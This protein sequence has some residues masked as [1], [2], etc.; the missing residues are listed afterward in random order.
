M[1]G[2]ITVILFILLAETKSENQTCKVI[3]QTGF[4]EFSKEGDLL[5]GGVF[6]M[7]STRTVIDNGY[8]AI[9]YTVCKK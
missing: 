2:W 1:M 5:I 3:G 6:S 7:S 4:L 9:P 8:Q